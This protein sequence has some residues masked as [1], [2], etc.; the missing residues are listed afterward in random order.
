LIISQVS[1]GFFRFL[2]VSSGFFRCP[3]SQISSG[4]FRFFDVSSDAQIP[5]FLRF[6]Q[7]P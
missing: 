3:D 7:V 5:G 6:P 4:F 1:S 2:Q